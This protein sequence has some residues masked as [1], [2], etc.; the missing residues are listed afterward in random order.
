MKIIKKSPA[1]ARLEIE[2]NNNEKS[3]IM[4]SSDI[5]YDSLGCDIDL[6]T[7][8]LKMAEE[9]QAPVLIAGDFLDVMQGKYD[10]RR[11]PEDLKE[12]Y[13]T[14]SYYDAVVADAA[15]FL[16]KFDIP[17]YILGE[18]NHENSVRMHTDH[19]LLSNL[20]YRLRY[21]Y[22]KQAINMG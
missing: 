14:S 2:A 7:S 1:V 15:D 22:K 4:L 20:S 17:V 9:L 11:N 16:G 6:L 3:F 21:E 19:D 10:P 5:H 13:K 18:G 8:H 12:K